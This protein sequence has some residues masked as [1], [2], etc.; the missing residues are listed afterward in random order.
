MSLASRTMSREYYIFLRKHFRLAPANVPV[1][2]EDDYHPLSNISAGTGHIQHR[3]RLLWNLGGVVAVDEGRTTSKSDHNAYKIRAPNKP[4]RMGWEW[5]SMNDRSTQRIGFIWS[6]LPLV[7]KYTIDPDEIQSENEPK[8]FQYVRNVT[9][10]IHGTGRMVVIDRKYFS[11]Q[12]MEV[13]RDEWGLR[14][15][16]T[17]CG[18]PKCLPQRIR[19]ANS[20][21]LK[22]ARIH[23]NKGDWYSYQ[24]DTGIN[25]H[26]FQHNAQ[27]RIADNCLDWDETWI[28]KDEY[29]DESSD[30]YEV[31]AAY[32]Y[33]NSCYHFSD[34]INQDASYFGMEYRTVRQRMSLAFK[35]IEMYGW[36]N[37]WIVY[38]EVQQRQGVEVVENQHKYGQR[39]FRKDIEGTPSPFTKKKIFLC[40]LS[41]SLAIG[42]SSTKSTI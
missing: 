24:S 3:S 23:W 2:G 17:I 18:K 36:I 29:S 8:M 9:K 6:H 13:A 26:V 32:H 1:P 10:D 31:P 37:P 38:Y 30:E 15:V 16:A 4:C 21:C 42:V 39:A 27:M 7:G 35:I 11:M 22:Y 19:F 20:K 28:I 33:Y 14:M 5:L 40:F 25:V 41:R 12:V 34:R